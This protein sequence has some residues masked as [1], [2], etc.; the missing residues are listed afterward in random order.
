MPS[1]LFIRVS[2]VVV[3]LGL[4]LALTVPVLLYLWGLS[5]VDGRPQRPISMAAA[6]EQSRIWKQAGGGWTC[7]RTRD[8]S[9]RVLWPFSR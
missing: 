4:L 8:E 3:S 9:L 7:R 2:A 6:D 5:N 1:R